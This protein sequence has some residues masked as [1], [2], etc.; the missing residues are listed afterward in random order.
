MDENQ[1]ETM[2]VFWIAP[3]LATLSQEVFSAKGWIFEE[4]FDG[5]RCIAV[6]FKGKVSLFSRNHKSLNRDF[7]EIQRI[8]EEKKSPD[9]VIDGEIVAFDGQVTSFSKL[10]KRGQEKI[11][12][13]YCVFDLLSW[14]GEKMTSL[15]LLE[16]KKRLKRDF[17]FGGVIRYTPHVL[18]KGEEFFQTA[19]RKGWEGIIAK[20]ADSPYL[21]KRT[22]DWLKCKCVNRQEFVIGGYTDPQ[23]SRLGFGALLIGYYSQGKLQY[24][25]KVGTGYDEKLLSSLGKRLSLLK[26]STCP[27]AICP[28]EKNVHFVKPILVCEVKFTEWTE[29]QKLRHP[30]FLGLRKDKTAKSVRKS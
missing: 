2:R 23:R 5:I 11:K 16:R 29:D 10:Q 15:P 26:Q 4:K 21:S 14:K 28:Q 13:Y 6:K 3:E 27:F 7:P 22:R 19:K 18:T 9:Y 12:A 17:P 1:D 24:A 30:S 8:L 25:G 20:R